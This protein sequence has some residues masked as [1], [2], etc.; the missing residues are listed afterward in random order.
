MSEPVLGAEPLSVIEWKIPDGEIQC[1]KQPIASENISE[2]I[3]FAVENVLL[4]NQVTAVL[5][6]LKPRL[7]AV[8]LGRKN[9]FRLQTRTLSRA[10]SQ[11]P[12]RATRLVP[13]EM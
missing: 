1:E 8:S 13:F 3:F 9:S 12:P 11:L 10:L 6:I 7:Y 4:K 5:A 2:K